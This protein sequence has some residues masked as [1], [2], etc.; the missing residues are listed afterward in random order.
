MHEYLRVHLTWQKNKLK[1]LKKC[2]QKR[3]N[4]CLLEDQKMSHA[5]CI[6]M[7]IKTKYLLSIVA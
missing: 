6:Y 7:S 2:S 5:I 1:K 3:S 4:S